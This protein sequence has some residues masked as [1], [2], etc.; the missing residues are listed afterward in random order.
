M[1]RF[2]KGR[3][4]SAFFLVIAIKN[5]I[6]VFLCG[7]VEKNKILGEFFAVKLLIKF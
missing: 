5:L 7:K 3:V 1:N 2:M 6:A 4:K